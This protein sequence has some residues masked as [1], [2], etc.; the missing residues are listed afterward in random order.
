MTAEGN[1]QTGDYW[2]ISL[3][4]HQ[5]GKPERLKNPVPM[6]CQL[7]LG[8]DSL[9]PVG[10]VSRLHLF[11]VKETGSIILDFLPVGSWNTKLS[12]LKLFP[13][14][15]KVLI[16]GCNCVGEGK[17]TPDQWQ[18]MVS[19]SYKW[20]P[21]HTR[22]ILRVYMDIRLLLVHLNMGIKNNLY[23]HY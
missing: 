5:S 22:Q 7:V 9:S 20:Y 15:A 6:F 16:M 2:A 8:E 18:S 1:S 14:M 17:I 23:P 12:T 11:S 21:I 3:N 4:S 19:Y 10:G 13:Y